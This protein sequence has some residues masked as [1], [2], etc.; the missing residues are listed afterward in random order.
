MGLFNFIYKLTNILSNKK[1]MRIF[2]IIAIAIVLVFCWSRGAFAY[3]SYSTP[4]DAQ[5]LANYQL[6]LQE[7]MITHLRY[8]YQSRPSGFDET[9]FKDLCDKLYYFNVF[10]SPGNYSGNP[11]S[12]IYEVFTYNMSSSNNADIFTT[13]GEWSIGITSGTAYPCMIGNVTANHFY[14]VVQGGGGRTT[15]LYVQPNYVFHLPDACYLIRSTYIDEFLNEMGYSNKLNTTTYN[16][17]DQETAAL[18]SSGFANEVNAVNNATTAINDVNSSVEDVN[19]SVMDMINTIVDPYVNVSQEQ[20]PQ[21]NVQDTTEDGLNNIFLII[22]DAFT[23]TPQSVSFPIP[24]TDKSFTIEP[25]FTENS[26]KKGGL[27]A[28]VSVIHLYWYY[29]IYSFIFLKYVE[30]LEK[31]KE[32]EFE[33]T[34]GNIKKEVL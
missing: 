11:A 26:M 22:K 5:A 9:V 31:L 4:E 25:G 27:N 29:R 2:L 33:E 18:I 6:L 14:K 28:M 17:H 8:L 15:P 24:F 21:S 34:V 7:S 13:Q 10:V 32:G 23:G 30:L 1:K 16:T 3:S 12:T 20:L 19:Q